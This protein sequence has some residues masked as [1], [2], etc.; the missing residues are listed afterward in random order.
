MKCKGTIKRDKK[1]EVCGNELHP[2]QIFCD[3][4]GEPT[5]ALKTDLSAKENFKYV[6]KEHRNSYQ[7]NLSL[8]LFLTLVVFL[9]MAIIA[10]ILWDNYLYTNITMLFIVPLAMIPFSMKEELSISEY[11]KHLKNYPVF[12]IFTALA[13]VYFFLLKVICTGYLLN[14]MVD[15]VLHIVRLIMVLYGLACAFSVPFLISGEKMNPFTAIANS[16][17][18]GHEPRWQLFF[19]LVQVA[20]VNAIG[21][22]F[23]LIG[24][25]YTLPF[26][27]KLMRRY[28]QKIVE[29]ELFKSKNPTLKSLE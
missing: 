8:G 15:A 21:A 23:L 18:A 28:Y 16:I 14:M 1:N 19:T 4:C 26:S 2:H 7:K 22:A 20:L 9:P 12:L 17:K 27:Y 3:V 29:Y 11:F 5:P 13:I 24:L 10:W 6:W 25:L